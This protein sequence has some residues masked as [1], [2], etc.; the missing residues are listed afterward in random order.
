MGF[1]IDYFITVIGELLPYLKNTLF[2][3]IISFIIALVLSLIIAYC[4]Q[5]K[6]AGLYQFFK[7]YISFFRS[8]PIISQLFFF[9]FGLSQVSE[10]IRDI[11]S[12]GALIII[13]SLNESAFMAET[14][15]GSF[16]SVDISQIEAGKSIGL[17][18]FQNAVYIVMPQAIRVAIPSLSNSFICLVKGTSIGFTVGVL[19]MMTMAKIEIARTYRGMEAYIAVLLIYWAVIILLSGAQKKL[20]VKLN[21]SY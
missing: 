19:E 3:S 12:V 16:L 20:E 11:S 10:F 2:I 4:I 13:L 18:R 15:R 17:T 14:I 5:Y 21:N 8:T 9:Y 6:I 7:V 1:K